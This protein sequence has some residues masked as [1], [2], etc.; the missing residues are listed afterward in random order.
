M[1]QRI[2]LLRD[3]PQK[4]IFAVYQNV[5]DR[6]IVLDYLNG[7]TVNLRRIKALTYKLG[8]NSEHGGRTVKYDPSTIEAERTIVVKNMVSSEEKFP[9]H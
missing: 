3:M 8:R 9:F 7:L 4:T 2:H 6:N 5:H 1:I